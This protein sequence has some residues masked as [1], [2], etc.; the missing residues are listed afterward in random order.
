MNG[1][2][3]SSASTTEYCANDKPSENK[4]SEPTVI[5]EQH[6]SESATPKNMAGMRLPARRLLCLSSQPIPIHRSS[7]NILRIRWTP[8]IPIAR[9]RS[10]AEGG[11]IPREPAKQPP[12]E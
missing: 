10:K 8:P 11:A 9:I 1:N 12:N 4:A 5:A 7:H 6:R 2:Q 3:H